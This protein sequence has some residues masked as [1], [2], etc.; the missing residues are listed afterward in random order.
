MDLGQKEKGKLKVTKMAFPPGTREGRSDGE[1]TAQ[2]E[3][4][5]G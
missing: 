2:V 1:R 4:V 3:D 5:L